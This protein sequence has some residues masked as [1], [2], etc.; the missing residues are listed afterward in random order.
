MSAL[1]TGLLQQVAAR[2]N[3]DSVVA[4]NARWY[5]ATLTLVCDEESWHF[6]VAEG[7]VNLTDDHALSTAPVVSIRGNSDDWRPVLRGL[8]GGLHRA[9]RHKLLVFE[10]DPVAMLSLWKTIWRLGEALSEVSEEN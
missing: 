10:G 4:S 5:R 6:T 9:F 7:R 3:A 1:T 2:L 8:R